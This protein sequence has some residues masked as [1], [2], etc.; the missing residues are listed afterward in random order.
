MGRS[1]DLELLHPGASRATGAPAFPLTRRLV[2]GAQ[3]QAPLRVFPGA[4]GSVISV[5][6][7]RRGA[8]SATGLGSRPRKHIPLAVPSGDGG[9]DGGDGGVGG[10]PGAAVLRSAAAAL[11]LRGEARGRRRRREGEPPSA[12][13]GAA[14]ARPAGEGPGRAGVGSEGRGGTEPPFRAGAGF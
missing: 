3:P 1:G 14:R 8:A 4:P 13:V 5:A 12:C 7:G 6:A 2:P 11:G 9:G 10:G